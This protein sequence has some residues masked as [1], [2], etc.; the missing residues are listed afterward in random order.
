MVNKCLGVKSLI[1]R[2]HILLV[3]YNEH[4]SEKYLFFMAKLTYFVEI[5]YCASLLSDIYYV[6]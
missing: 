4:S 5:Y 1:K 3:K 2:S 6:M